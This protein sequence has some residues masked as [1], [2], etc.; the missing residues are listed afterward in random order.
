M[1]RSHARWAIL[2]AEQGRHV[3]SRLEHRRQRAHRQHQNQ[4]QGRAQQS[5]ASIKQLSPKYQ[6]PAEAW[7]VT[8]LRGL[9]IAEAAWL[10]RVDEEALVVGLEVT[11]SKGAAVR[12]AAKGGRVVVFLVPGPVSA[13]RRVGGEDEAGDEE[14]DGEGGEDYG[15]DFLSRRGSRHGEPQ[16]SNE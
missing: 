13:G 2:A 14:E 4:E 11:G 10:A 7:A 9:G 8:S 5:V 6:L 16:A 3:D 1:A 12:D 15:R